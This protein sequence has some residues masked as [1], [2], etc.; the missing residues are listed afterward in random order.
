[1]VVFDQGGLRLGE[2]PEFRFALI[3]VNSLYGTEGAVLEPAGQKIG[4]VIRS[5]LVSGAEESA[6]IGRPI[7][8]AREANI[9]ACGDL[10]AKR[11]PV[12]GDIARPQGGGVALL[13]GIGRA[14]E[15]HHPL[16]G[17]VLA[18]AVIDGP[19]RKERIGVAILVS[20]A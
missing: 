13:P 2:L 5:V 8:Q 6:A 7:G 4:I 17:S 12:R 14:G 1:M 3:S 16:V 10:A 18:L 20:R 11:L 15:D 9:Q 19:V